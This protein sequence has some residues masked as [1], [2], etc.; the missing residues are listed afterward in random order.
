[1]M[2]KQQ[3]TLHL[4]LPVPAHSLALQP[5]LHLDIYALIVLLQ[6]RVR[7]HNHQPLLHVDIYIRSLSYHNYF[8]YNKRVLYFHS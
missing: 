3:M 5:P 6:L 2:A 4:Q 8:N 1:M 7:A